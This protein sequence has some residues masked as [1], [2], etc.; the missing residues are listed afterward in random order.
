MKKTIIWNNKQP[1][2]NFVPAQNGFDGILNKHIGY[3]QERARM[4]R[5]YGIIGVSALVAL[6]SCIAVFLIYKEADLVKSTNQMATVIN[7]PVALSQKHIKIPEVAFTENAVK[8]N[9][10][11]KLND[12]SLQNIQVSDSITKGHINTASTKSKKKTD[13]QKP[14][15]VFTKAYP[16]HGFQVFYTYLNTQ[17]DSLLLIQHIVL[18]QK[19]QIIFEINEVGSAEKISVIGLENSTLEK[20]LTAIVRD[21]PNWEPATVNAKP[22]S[23]KFSLPI[24]LSYQKKE[25]ETITNQ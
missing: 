13:T 2:E 8:S 11:E 23:S 21:I 5:L 1:V 22:I 15:S 17:I 6:I 19:I 4:R 7:T 25:I 20:E 18:N 12:N 3:T 24:T 14:L 9:L 10:K 16:R